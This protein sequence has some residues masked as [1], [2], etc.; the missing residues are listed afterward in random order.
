MTEV[1]ET[2]GETPVL[3]PAGGVD[4]HAEAR[5]AAEV[6]QDGAETGSGEAKAPE[7]ENVPPAPEPTATD[8]STAPGEVLTQPTPEQQAEIDSMVDFTITEETLGEFPATLP[9]GTPVTVG[10][11]VK[12]AKDHPL[13]ATQGGEGVAPTN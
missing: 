7:T 13:L 1:P 9:D 8:A 2:N 4:T 5:E 3:H 6:A 11:V 10:M 12:L